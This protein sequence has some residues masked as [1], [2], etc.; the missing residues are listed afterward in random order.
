[1]LDLLNFQYHTSEVNNLLD[2]C[3]A[4]GKNVSWLVEDSV[5]NKRE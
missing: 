3:L 1:M 2:N 4:G 5:N